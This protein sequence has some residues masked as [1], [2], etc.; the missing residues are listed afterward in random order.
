MAARWRRSRPPHSP[1][2]TELPPET[3][4]AYAATL[5]AEAGDGRRTAAEAPDVNAL[6][7]N[8]D[9]R[10]GLAK[11]AK[12]GRR[13][14]T[15]SRP[16]SR[17]VAP[18]ARRR[19]AARP[20]CAQPAKPRRPPVL[21]QAEATEAAEAAAQSHATSAKR[22]ARKPT[23]ARPPHGAAKPAPA[24]AAPAKGAAVAHE[25]TPAKPRRRRRRRP[26]NRPGRA[27]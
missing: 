25:S 18:R 5:A 22:R 24:E 16:R 12:V 21:P 23:P 1:V 27:W 19:D 6:P 20:S 9:V 3:A 14:R 11:R 2:G 4:S 7:L 10:R 13:G 15:K 26:I 8:I 17:P